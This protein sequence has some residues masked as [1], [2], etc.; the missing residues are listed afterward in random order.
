MQVEKEQYMLVYV[1]DS[2]ENFTS[3]LIISTVLKFFYN[4]CQ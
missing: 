3:E 1:D 2:M 4:H